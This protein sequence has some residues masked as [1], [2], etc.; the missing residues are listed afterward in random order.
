M[1]DPVKTILVVAAHPDD[2]DVGCGGSVPK[3]VSQGAE[4]ILCVTTNGEKG[5]A[6][7]EM[8]PDKLQAIRDEEQREAARIM[9]IKEVIIL[10]N[11]DGELADNYEFRGQLVRLL[12]KYRPDRVVTHN[13]YIWQHRDHRMSGQVTLDAVYPYARDRL[14]YP[15][16]E[17]EGLT[18]YKTREV[19]LWTGMNNAEWDVEEDVTDF[20]EVKIEAIAAH[21]SQFGPPA[22][23]RERWMS[24]WADRSKENNG[25][26]YERFKRVEYNV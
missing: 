13:P 24:R 11:K 12:R 15:E 16:L 5:S 18:P 23:T 26:F 20:V 10:P 2:C 19:Y 9:G 7:K 3:W 14:H 21:V 1:S 22:E 4:V 25:K 8:T 6:D 17:Q